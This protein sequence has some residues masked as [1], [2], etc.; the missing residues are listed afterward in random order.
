MIKKTRTDSL[1]SKRPHTI[2]KTNDKI[3]IDNTIAGSM[4]ARLN[5]AY[6]YNE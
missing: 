3:Y 2:T 5:I 1:Q 6:Y 4:N